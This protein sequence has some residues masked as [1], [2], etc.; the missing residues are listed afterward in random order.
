L[1][2][3]NMGDELAARFTQITSDEQA[4]E[5]IL[6]ATILDPDELLHFVNYLAGYFK[7]RNDAQAGRPPS[8]TP[9]M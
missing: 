8:Q 1:G 2:E 5:C 3:D 9:S 6:M 4:K 7:G